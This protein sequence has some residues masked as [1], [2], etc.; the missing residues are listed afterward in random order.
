MAHSKR[1]VRYALCAVGGASA[2]GILD[3]KSSWYGQMQM[4]TFLTPVRKLFAVSKSL[5]RDAW[6]GVTPLLCEAFAKL[7]HPQQ[8]FP[9]PKM[10]WL[11]P[12]SS[13]SRVRLISVLLS[14]GGT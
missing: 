10:S 11:F 2:D 5:L 8:K 12:R 4:V 6:T 1:H 3:S 9:R 7:W 14:K 13:S